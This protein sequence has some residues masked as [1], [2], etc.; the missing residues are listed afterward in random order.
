MRSQTTGRAGLTLEIL[1][2]RILSIFLISVSDNEP[3]IKSF[4]SV[5]ENINFMSDIE[6]VSTKNPEHIVI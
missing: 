6:R 2:T 4:R 1:K 3:K 5:I